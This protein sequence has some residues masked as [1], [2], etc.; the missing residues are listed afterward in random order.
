M[1]AEGESFD[2]KYTMYAFVVII[3]F[4]YLSSLPSFQ[5][6]FFSLSVYFQVRKNVKLHALRSYSAFS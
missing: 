2:T 3:Q 6:P 1:V 5:N 4:L